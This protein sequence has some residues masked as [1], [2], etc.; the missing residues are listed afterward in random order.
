M[1]FSYNSPFSGFNGQ[2]FRFS[3]QQT[4]CVGQWRS[5]LDNCG[6][7]GGEGHIFTYSCSTIYQ[8]LLKSI[9]L[10]SVNTNIWIWAQTLSIIKFREPL[11]IGISKVLSA[12]WP[13]SIREPV[14]FSKMRKIALVRRASAIWSPVRKTHECIFCKLPTKNFSSYYLLTIHQKTYYEG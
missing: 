6:R 14:S 13:K 2:E 1:K 10:W 12:I 8:F 7:G 9:V 4:V 5:K 3:K 11:S